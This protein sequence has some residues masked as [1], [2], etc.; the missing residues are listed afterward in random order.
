MTISKNV[1]QDVLRVFRKG[2]P[3]I[4]FSDGTE[5]EFIDWTSQGADIYRDLLHLPPK[6]FRGAT[7]IDF[8]AG[9]GE[10]TIH[11]ANRGVR[12]LW[13]KSTTMP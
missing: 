11:F 4:H 10:N 9:T 3:S 5:K 7:L 12:A 6:M 8:G 2:I 13:S 1:E